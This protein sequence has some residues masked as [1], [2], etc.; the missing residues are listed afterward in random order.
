MKKYVVL[1]VL[2]FLIGILLIV[3]IDKLNNN[4]DSSDLK[5]NNEE[6]KETENTNITNSSIESDDSIISINNDVEDEKIDSIKESDSNT[7]ETED[8]SDENIEGE[9]YDKEQ[10]YFENV[11]ILY[12]FLSFNQVEDLKLE[13]QDYIHTYKSSEYL[14]CTVT[15]AYE[16]E[17]NVEFTVKF[18]VYELF[19]IVELEND[20]IENFTISE[21]EEL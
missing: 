12:D 20:S 21:I 8:L 9:A 11:L 14:D 16:K 17:G 19:I 15:S 13:I 4:N 6:V 10:M 5:S 7:I 1:I 3:G 2:V 18:D